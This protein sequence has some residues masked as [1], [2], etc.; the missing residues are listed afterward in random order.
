MCKS[1]R[2]ACTRECACVE[3][4]PRLNVPWRE[5]SQTVLTRMFGRSKSNLTQ[6]RERLRGRRGSVRALDVH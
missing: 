6:H 1:V 4:R 5:L 3:E 2:V